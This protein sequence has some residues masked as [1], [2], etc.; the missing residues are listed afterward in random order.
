M[1]VAVNGQLHLGVK[2]SYGVSYTE[3][4]AKEFTSVSPV[5]L[6]QIAYQGTQSRKGVGMSVYKA[7]QKLF[8]MADGLYTKSGRTFTLE[9]TNFQRTPLD[10][11]ILY[12]TSE[13]NLRLVVMSGLRYKNLKLGV[14]PEFSRIITSVEE[15][16]E[17]EGV[18]NSGSNFQSGFNFLVGYVFGK[19]IHLDLRHTYIFQD[20]A[21]EFRFDG[22]PL[23]FNANQKY[24]E[25]SLG[26]YW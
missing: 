14:G 24:V 20:A 10:P 16:S 25:I 17:L 7:N 19:H 22:V 3:S 4:V 26:F 1:T 2:T 5:K 18:S 11:A 23:D 8:F 12:N 13:T 15:L 9:S 21:D 6:S